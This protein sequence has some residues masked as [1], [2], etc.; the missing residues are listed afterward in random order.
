MKHIKSYRIFEE[1]KSTQVSIPPKDEII[2]MLRRNFANYTKPESTFPVE[3][4]NKKGETIKTLEFHFDRDGE[5]HMKENLSEGKF[6]KGLA[7]LCLIGGML[8]SCDKGDLYNIGNDA[9]YRL[10]PE[11]LS[12]LGKPAF[13]N[14]NTGK[15]YIYIWAGNQG[16]TQGRHGYYEFS[17]DSNKNYGAIYKEYPDSFGAGDGWNVPNE[18]LKVVKTDETVYPLTPEQKSKYKYLVLVK[19]HPSTKWDW[20]DINKE[21]EVPFEDIGTGYSL[22]LTNLE[23]IK[24]GDLYPSWPT[25]VYYGFP[26]DDSQ[27]KLGIIRDRQKIVALRNYG[28][29]GWDLEKEEPSI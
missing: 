6:T 29:K 28:P 15:Q 27:S 4:K 3:V 12:H 23:T 24:K 17:N 2:K 14:P 9:R 18:V 20:T 25:T 8:T 13:D 21:K 22:Y 16:G 5:L 7:A 19:V 26:K 1:E 11:I 10:R